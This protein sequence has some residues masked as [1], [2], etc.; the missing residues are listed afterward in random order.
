MNCTINNRTRIIKPA[1]KAIG[2]LVMMTLVFQ[3]DM[4]LAAENA[5]KET[6]KSALYGGAAGG[7]VGAA[8]LA[9][10]KKPADHLQY[11]AYG[12]AGGV[13]AGT[14]YGVVRTSRALA[15]YEDGKLRFAVPAISPTITEHHAT[16]RTNITWRANLLSGTFN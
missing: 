11:I 5:F 7:L 10:T 3:A 12:A 15:E 13:I 9:F 6:F 16:G 1:C 8:I 14:V 4:S 2:L